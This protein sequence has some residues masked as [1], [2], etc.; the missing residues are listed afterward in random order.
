MVSLSWAV[1]RGI[2]VIPKSGTPARIEENIRLVTLTD[3]E[4]ETMNNAHRTVGKVR[5]SDGITSLQ[6]DIPGK[7]V[8]LLGWTNQ[9]FG[10]E[11]EQ[12]NW[13]T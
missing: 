11:D 10:F 13:L 9:E 8:T 1:Q 2:V 12:G 4:M 5:I 7:G 6:Y 3:E